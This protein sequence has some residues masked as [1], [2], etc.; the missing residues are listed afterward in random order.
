MLTL[1]QS[2]LIFNKL[3]ISEHWIRFQDVPD[4]VKC[5]LLFTRFWDEIFMCDWLTQ[6]KQLYQLCRDVSRIEM[7]LHDLI[8]VRNREVIFAH[9]N[10]SVP[11]WR[12]LAEQLERCFDGIIT[13]HNLRRNLEVEFGYCGMF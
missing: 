11:F 12:H 1:T 8:F 7:S 4:L 5:D 13:F 2:F 10:H 6:E 9:N 3:S